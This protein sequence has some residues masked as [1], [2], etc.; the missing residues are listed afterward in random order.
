[1]ASLVWECEPVSLHR[2]KCEDILLHQLL[3]ANLAAPV[4]RMLEIEGK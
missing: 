1:M 3:L 4:M 2:G